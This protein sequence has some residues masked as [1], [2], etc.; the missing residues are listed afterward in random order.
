MEIKKATLRDIGGMKK[1]LYDA[2]HNHYAAAGEFYAIEQLVDPNYATQ[3]G[4]YYSKEMFISE[5][6]KSLKRRLRPPFQAFVAK[7]QGKIIG[8]IIC[9][10]HKGKL[11]V[12]DIVVRREYQKKDVGKK[13]F[14]EAIRDKKVYLWVNAKNPAKEF[15]KKLGFKEILREILM[16]KK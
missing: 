4:P 3:T 11:W 8:Y 10:K 15:W 13:L 16:I 5:N 14:K 7:D 9:E 6:A 2:F 12:N 1:V